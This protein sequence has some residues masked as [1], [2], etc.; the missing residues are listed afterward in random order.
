MK[1]EPEFKKALQ[2]LPEDA[3]DKLILRLL[4]HDVLLA[5]KLRFELIDTENAQDKRLQLEKR[6]NDRIRIATENYH[7]PAYL[8]MD[9]RSIVSD[10]NEHVAI[11]KDKYGEIS[12]NCL[13]LN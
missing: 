9:I 10:I 5:N 3:K 7:S 4:K 12:L 8:L 6:M 11:T 13:L 2:S 1:F